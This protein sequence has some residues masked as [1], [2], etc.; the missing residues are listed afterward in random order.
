MA[1]L[2]GR[3]L[4]ELLLLEYPDTVDDPLCSAVEKDSVEKR[5]R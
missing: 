5:I 3:E 1:D 4:V 2:S